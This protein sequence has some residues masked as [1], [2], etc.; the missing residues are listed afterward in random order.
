MRLTSRLGSW[1][2]FALRRGAIMVKCRECAFLTA[3][4]LTDLQYVEISSYVR[5]TGDV[6]YVSGTGVGTPV[7]NPVPVCFVGAAP[8][9][10]EVTN[11]T[12]NEFLRV[13]SVERDCPEF[14][15]W[16]PSRGPREHKEML[17]Q[18]RMLEWQEA[19]LQKDREWKE[20]RLLADKK[21]A[22]AQRERDRAFQLQLRTDDR[23]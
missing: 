10:E 18:K 12:K 14:S 16:Q 6:P 5:K 13:I 2:M 22:E 8:I 23:E 19:R 20:E 15:Q 9:N 3:H 21:S 11:R 17:D 4:R 7:Y 1:T